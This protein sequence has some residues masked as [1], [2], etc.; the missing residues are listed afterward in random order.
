[1]AKGG[2]FKLTP[3]EEERRAA[4]PERVV[5]LDIIYECDLSR[6]AKESR[7]KIAEFLEWQYP[8]DADIQLLAIRIHPDRR[9]G[10]PD[11]HALLMRISNRY[12]NLP[13][14]DHIQKIV[15][16]LDPSRRVR[17]QDANAL[18][19][20]RFYELILSGMKKTP[21]INQVADEFYMTADKVRK[22]IPA[23]RNF[24]PG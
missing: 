3:E 4:L 13:R 21:A 9:A 24:S 14:Y 11:F 10:I 7:R 22:T 12:D 15:K 17:H 5:D 1:M 18:V 19:I 23:I 6:G 8:H 16:R 2:F 20:H